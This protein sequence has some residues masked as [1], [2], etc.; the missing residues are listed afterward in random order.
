MSLHGVV[1]P[2]IAANAILDRFREPNVAS[3]LHDAD[4]PTTVSGLALRSVL[5]FAD[6]PATV[7]A[8]IPVRLPVRAS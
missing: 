2:A 3:L 8:S 5:E 7:V 4:F 6:V 1:S